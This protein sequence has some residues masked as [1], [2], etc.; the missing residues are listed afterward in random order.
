MRK[1]RILVILICISS[2]LAACATQVTVIPTNTEKP[3]IT[4]PPDITK[5]PIGNPFP[6]SR[7][8]I[9]WPFAADSI[10]NMPIHE[11]AKYVDAQ[12]GMP[13]EAGLTIDPEILILQPNAPLKPLVENNAGWDGNPRC[14]SLTGN[15][16][17][18]A[19]PVP[20][21]FATYPEEA[22]ST[23]N[24]SSAILMPD[25]VTLYQT[26]PLHVCSAGGVVTSQYLWE[27]QN[28]RTDAGIEGSHGGSGMTAFGGSIR[29][30]E[31][32][33]GS[34][35]HHAIKMNFFAKR[36]YSFGTDD[37]PGYRWPAPRADGY[38]S[39]ETY[40]GNI[41]AFEIGALLALKSDFDVI[42]LQTEPARII[43]RAAQDYGIYA[44]DD[45]AWDVFALL[46]EEGAQG[47]VTDQFRKVYGYDI[48]GPALNC[49]DMSDAC[50]W[51][52]DMWTILK[53]LNVVDNNS[54][55]TIGGGP[56]SDTVNRRAPMAPPFI[57][58]VPTATPTFGP[59]PTMTLTPTRT[60]TPTIT[61]TPTVTNTYVWVGGL[62]N[63]AAADSADAVDLTMEGATDWA[64]FYTTVDRKSDGGSLIMHTIIGGAPASYPDDLRPISWTDGMPTVSSTNDTSGLYISGL[65]NGFQLVVPADKTTRTIKVY[66]GGWN[67]T[68]TLNAH[69]S[70]GSTVD[71]NF[72]GAAFSD[73]YDYV[74]TLTFHAA[75]AGQTL[76]IQW[77]QS[78]GSGNVA[79]NAAALQ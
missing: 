29:V 52:Q 3:A 27:P 74:F 31:L 40:G 2:V 4:A 11:D 13:M 14:T 43:A 5:A 64:H 20:N 32:V 78:A 42:S 25:G 28:I 56:N 26:Q 50:K 58:P 61:F 63:G 12:I 16:L 15:I 41:P 45:T 77:T 48:E 18:P 46:V 57:P 22:G 76:T 24:N 73:A 17:L 1:I 49:T 55:T 70:D 59:S 30:G 69:L 66:V 9:Y 19:V 6:T 54:A 38:A 23:P 68:G 65:N 8:P 36:N 75:S 35:I 21:D 39:A 47:S 34:V 67:S 44:V 72:T 62:L 51:S 7:D 71:Y 33:P 53:N 60:I 79:L 37:T 10:W